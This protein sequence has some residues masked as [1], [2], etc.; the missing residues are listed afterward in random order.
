ML[1]S[2]FDP[3]KIFDNPVQQVL[4]FLLIYLVVV[5]P[6]FF[7]GMIFVTIFSVMAEHIQAVYF[8]DLVGAGIGCVIFLPF[9]PY[10]GPGGLLVCAAGLMLGVT[11]LMTTNRAARVGA[12]VAG[13]ALVGF[14]V[15]LLPGYLEFPNLWDKREVAEM[16]DDG[17][18]EF[19]SWDEVAKI[20]VVDVG[21]RTKLDMVPFCCYKHI[22]YDGGNQSSRLF[23]LEQSTDELR[24]QLDAGEGNL[25][26]HFWFEGVVASHYFKRDSDQD[27]LIIG[28]AGGQE[29][30]AALA[31][32]AGHIDAVEMVGTVVDLVN[33][34]YSDYIGGIYQDPRVNLVQGEG[35]SFL[36]STDKLY[37][38]IQIFSNHTSSSA[39]SASSAVG[40][41][42]LQT[43]EAYQE[44]FSHLK[45]DGVL[46]VNHHVYPRVITTAALAWRQ[47]GLPSDFQDHVVVFERS[48][49]WRDNLPTIMIKMTP[50]TDA[51][52]E[53][54]QSGLESLPEALLPIDMVVDPRDREGSFLSRD[55]FTGE[56]PDALADEMPYNVRPSVD[57]Q[58]YFNFLRKRLSLLEPQPELFLNASTAR[59]L[60]KIMPG[61]V[62]PL[63]LIHLFVT[64]FAAALFAILFVLVPMLFSRAG[65]A[66]WPG[67]SVFLVY[68]SCLGFGFIILELVL[69]QIFMNLIGFPLYTYSTVIF[70]MLVAAGIGSLASGRMGISP[71]QHWPWPFVGAIAAALILLY[72]YPYAFELGLSLPMVGRI[73]IAVALLFPLG[74]FLGMPFPLGILTIV[75]R[76]KGAVAWAWALNAVFTVVGGY[77]AI[78]S[79]VFFGFHTTIMAGIGTYV[80]AFVAFVLLR[81]AGQRMAVL[82]PA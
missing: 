39:A 42:F 21:E 52:L 29:T 1:T 5:L 31:Y 36:R 15:T 28:A 7:L 35:R 16:I 32:G 56:F 55:F 75:D 47:M 40:T 12:V 45:E 11:A 72:I 66:N 57:D 38:I 76:P 48:Y 82:Q 49:M 13:V 9:L 63:D 26:D 81:Q 74:F 64:G 54:M 43:A 41:S 19:S 44:Y 27:V 59:T 34:P 58:P 80:I 73:L 2:G 24:Q 68:F 53:E 17:R 10:F 23:L 4:S 33:G 14:P 70:T 37:D 25:Y 8:W 69:I 79:S 61:G 6:F 46:H 18:R 67:K 71:A 77:F 78:L 65:K 51:E 50:W 22:A 3:E 60:N 30:K 20:D 62:L